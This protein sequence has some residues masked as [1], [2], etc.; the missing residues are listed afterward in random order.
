MAL[1]QRY[2]AGTAWVKVSP[3]FR[4]WHKKMREQVKNASDEYLTKASLDLDTK[5]ARATL[6]EFEANDANVT[7]N[8]KVDK[9]DLARARAQLDALDKNRRV[10][11]VRTEIDN[12]RVRQQIKGLDKK[13]QDVAFRPDIKINEK[14]INKQFDKLR[15]R[16]AKLS[17]DGVAVDSKAYKNALDSAARL[18][19][20]ENE[21][22]RASK[23]RES[24]EKSINDESEQAN[25]RYNKVVRERAGLNRE[26]KRIQDDLAKSTADIV[27]LEN[28]SAK[29][30]ERKAELAE[31]EAQAKKDTR[32]H[33]RALRDLDARRT[34][35]RT[36][37]DRNAAALPG[38]NERAARIR[39]TGN[40]ADW[41]IE[42][43]II[44]AFQKVRKD[45]NGSANIADL[46]EQ[47]KGVSR[48]D[49][50]NAIRRISDRKGA[51]AYPN[52]DRGSLTNRDRAN[53]VRI[54]THENHKLSLEGYQE[55]KKP[56][57]ALSKADEATI[58][59]QKALH[60]Q[61]AADEQEIKRLSDER[62]KIR[63]AIDAAKKRE[64]RAT[65]SAADIGDG[66]TQAADL[67]AAKQRKI[68]NEKA[69]LKTQ[70]KLENSVEDLA[71]AYE[72]LDRVRSKGNQR[73]ISEL[74][75]I[76]KE[77][78]RLTKSR[79][80]ASRVL[81]RTRR[82][83]DASALPAGDRNSKI[84]RPGLESTE[85][86]KSTDHVERVESAIR[87][88]NIGNSPLTTDVSAM[89]NA[90][91]AAAALD[92][93]LA[94]L[95]RSESDLAR[96]ERDV[97]AATAEVNRHRAAGTVT[98]DK[99][100]AA[101]DRETRALE[102]YHSVANTIQ[103]TSQKVNRLRGD[104]NRMAG[105]LN[106][107]LN[108]NGIRRWADTLD[109]KI[110]Q[111]VTKAT[112]RVVLLG[113][114][115]SSVATLAGASAMGFAALGAVNLVPLVG[116]LSQVA[117][118]LGILPGLAAAA[119][120]AIAAIGIGMSGITSA[121]KAGSSMDDAIGAGGGGADNSKAVRS[122]QKAL[123]KAQE[124][125]GKTAQRGAEQVADAEKNV[126]NAQKDSVKA[127]K[128]LTAARKDA[129]QQA[130]DLKAAV[131]GIALSEE[132][133][134][135]S[136]E[137]AA[138]R[139]REVNAD[140]ES[141]S[142][143]RRRA[144]L[145]YK[146]AIE[147]QKNLRKEN[148]KTREE[149]AETQRKGV[150]GS[151][152]VVEAQERVKDAQQGI[153]DAQRDLARTQR[154]AAEANADAIDRV[155]DAQ[156]SLADAMNGGGG[157]GGPTPLDKFNAELD[158]LAP[159]AQ[160]LV[161]GLRSLKDEWTDLRKSTQQS[162]FHGVAEDVMQLAEKYFPLL[163]KGLGDTA[164]GLN[165][166][167]RHFFT[168]LKSEK[169]YLD[170]TSIFNNSG[171]A[172]GNLS[173]ATS[174]FMQALGSVAE[175]GTRFMPWF[176][177]SIAD[178]AKSWRSM[179]DDAQADGSMEAY[180]VR[181]INRSKQLGRIFYDLGSIIKSTFTATEGLGNDSMLHIER[182]LDSYAKK[183]KETAGQNGVREF[184]QSIRN[185]LHDSAQ[186]LGNIAKLVTQHLVPAF[187]MING[188]VGPVVQAI[189]AMSTAIGQIP[190]LGAGI[191]YLVAAMLALKI[192]STAGGVAGKIGDKVSPAAMTGLRNMRTALNNIGSA[193][194]TAQNG[195]RGAT[196]AVAPLSS[197]LTT[198]GQNAKVTS[199]YLRDAGN[200]AKQVGVGAGAF[201]F[202]GP[203]SQ[204]T[205]FS[206][207]V[208]GASANVS[209]LG[210]TIRTNASASILSRL[211][212]GFTSFGNS[213]SNAFGRVQSAGSTAF[214]K[215]RSLGST[216]VDFLG[217][218]VGIAITGVV[219]GL[220][221]WYAHTQK[222][223]SANDQLN[224][225]LV[226]AAA[227][228]KKA[229]Q[230]IIEAR[231]GDDPEVSAAYTS[232]VED[233]MQ[234]NKDLLEKLKT[235]N[236]KTGILSS[237]LSGDDEGLK[238]DNGS[239]GSRDQEQQDRIQRQIDVLNKL[240]I[241]SEDVGSAITGTNDQWRSFSQM[242]MNEGSPAAQQVL[243]D[244]QNQ[245][246]E[247]I[248][249]RDAV[250]DLTPGYLDLRD[251]LET[252]SDKTISAAD[253][254]DALR[255]AFRALNPA[256]TK[257]EALG[258]FGDMIDEMRQKIQS[259]S[260]EGGFG[261]EQL[262]AP[263]G[264]LDTTKQ[265]ANTLFKMM[266][267]GFANLGAAVKNG[268]EFEPLW[269]QFTDQLYQFGDAVGISRD[270]MDGLLKRMG[271][272][273][274][275]IRTTV[276]VEGADTVTQTLA[277]IK[278]LAEQATARGEPR[279]IKMEI[280]DTKV[281]DALTAM[282]IQLNSIAGQPNMVEVNLE[283]HDTYQKLLAIQ[284][285]ITGT[286][287]TWENFRASV[288]QGADGRIRIDNNI[289][290]VQE[291]LNNLKIRTETLPDGSIAII[292]QDEAYYAA[293]VNATKP[294]SVDITFNPKF[295]NQE[296]FDKFL[297][298]DPRAYGP[299]RDTPGNYRGGKIPAFGVGGRMPTTGPGTEK[300]DGFLAVGPDGKPQARVDGGEWVINAAMSHKYN[301]LL[302]LI[303]SDKL[304]GF[305]AGGQMPGAAPAK[306]K[307]GAFGL[308]DVG[309]PFAGMASGV[310]GL[311]AAFGD[312][313][314]TAIPEW[315]QFGNT[316]SSTASKF[317]S[318]ALSSVNSAI[319]EMG[320]DFPLITQT[321]IIPPWSQMASFLSGQK[322]GVLDPMFAG[323][324]SSATQMGNWFTTMQGIVQ[325]TWLSM[326]TQ[327]MAAKTGTIDP[328]FAGIESGL[329]TVESA[330]SNAVP[331]IATLWNGMR[332]ATAAPVRFT[333]NTVLNDG[334]IAAW[335]SVADTIGSK[336]MTGKPAAFARGGV[337][338]GYTP[339]R[340]VH[341][342]FSPTGGELH[343]SGGEAVMRPEWVRA[344]GG[345]S[346]IDKM[347]AEA[348]QGVAKKQPRNR[349]T[350]VDYANG[351]TVALGYGLPPGSSVSYGAAGFPDWVYAL[352]RAHGVQP[353][354]YPGHQ[355]SDRGE[356]GYAPNPQH[357]NRGIDWSGPIPAMDG[358]ARYLLGI[359][360]STPTLEQIIWQNPNTGQQIGW[361]GRQP[362]I[363]GG[364][365]AADYPGHTD[366]VHTRQSGPIAP[367]AVASALG[368]FTGGA[369]GA[370]LD[371]SAYIK[372]ILDP[373]LAETQ[374][375][376]TATKF[377]G[378]TG[379]IPQ[380][381]F[382]T[383]K[384]KLVDKAIE[385]AKKSPLFTAAAGAAADYASGANIPGDVAEKVRKAFELYGWG[386]GAEWEAAKWIIT[387]ESGW[388][389][390][391]VNP[392]S[393][394]W[395]LFQF[396]GA[397][398]DNYYPTNDPD[399][400]KQGQA[401]AKYMKDRYGTPSAAKAFWQAHN[402]YDRG[403]MWPSGTGG[404]NMS[405]KPEAVFTNPQWKMLEKLV[406]SLLNPRMFR[407]LTDQKKVSLG[408]T[409]APLTQ[410]APVPLGD[411]T[412][413]QPASARKREYTPAWEDPGTKAPYITDPETGVPI[414]PKTNKAFTED[415]DSHKPI[416]KDDAT[417]LYVD[418]RTGKYFYGSNAS[419][420]DAKATTGSNAPKRSYTPAW[421]DKD[422][423]PY[424]VDPVTGVPINPDT[425]KPFE[426]DPE[427]HSDIKLDDTTGL[428]VDPK[429]GSYFYGSKA[430]ELDEKDGNKQGTAAIDPE[431]QFSFDDPNNPDGNS[432]DWTENY[433]GPFSDIIK[434]GKLLGTLGQA[435]MQPGAIQRIGN[436]QEMNKQI[437]IAKKRED[438]LN[439]YKTDMAQQISELRAA[440]KTKEA[441]AL[442]AQARGKIAQMKELPGSTPGTQAML[443]TME[444]NPSETWKKQSA[445]QWQSW[446]GEN[447]AGI[448][449][450]AAVM[451]AQGAG[452]VGGGLTVMG[453]L[454]TGDGMRSV[455][456]E[457]DRREARASRANARR[458]RR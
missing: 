47:V 170:F 370:V 323:I 113:R 321:K 36:R 305:A 160:G 115:F 304:E 41:D 346:A 456:R 427:T 383:G 173:I 187:Q 376:I 313:L 399:P 137:E 358:F 159:N 176:S 302:G 76:D 66:S 203:T 449:E 73:E 198:L 433:T 156:E 284:S 303:N 38:V 241:S 236:S 359:A 290:G 396:L 177:R 299:G 78:A 80:A 16:V 247:F 158:K 390:T 57:Q 348:R 378:T 371:A 414:D 375:K 184:F 141:D 199:Q 339:G 87:K 251:A 100:I 380:G 397:T 446:L 62:K 412:Q 350:G 152:Q 217:G 210:N 327:I 330:F 92:S 300:R 420:L 79:D 410:A 452:Q 75:A 56:R 365:F 415:P 328:V 98:S 230:A 189:A 417:G 409:P 227:S 408:A 202:T 150:E 114:V 194:T 260:S 54:G 29:H 243:R 90:R 436:D 257:L 23:Q 451:G 423:K 64:K 404:I 22:L 205:N 179:A 443:A 428:Y 368:D 341:K 102:K 17:N 379:S 97:A 6:R 440:G 136:V 1:D 385:L 226:R 374:K 11:S 279:I 188:I 111:A 51:L 149:Y 183:L 254:T 119:A 25:E 218:P 157:G 343:L 274:D 96:T 138:K 406:E 337:L 24:I 148:Q 196:A 252:L 235:K 400:Y 147:S 294:R 186:I 373:K 285:A 139:M 248:R 130:E 44:R 48:A 401:G 363:G 121:F 126:Q 145:S 99:G 229:Q 387:H 320:T 167:F 455:I 310:M 389:P 86:D 219:V 190:V 224:A 163:K 68:D 318:P 164:A 351:G 5:E 49:F 214:S 297:A 135:L 144:R 61:I 131:D 206:N 35:I 43:Q 200:A 109:H 298:G 239:R 426:E 429:T 306:K 250:Q 132:D 45:G 112:S 418:P 309:N 70:G 342:F 386:S 213:A 353:S 402:W 419:D 262:L 364:Y 88:A 222:L 354:T 197:R 83:L 422:G 52:D 59:R 322:T 278:M 50:D 333:I 445:Q 93:E 172:M 344:Q 435:L 393:G 347:N 178:T 72:D 255:K 233:Q 20:I 421:T 118:A 94:R 237:L 434:K 60:D 392:S 349:N 21:R 211:G 77:L 71:N 362:D 275:N 335:N 208:K 191:K 174:N 122:A 444:K 384:G 282:G 101:V 4:N 65:T 153:V 18:D 291:L 381:A 63:A 123:T 281:R 168:Y 336:K 165:D 32:Q 450:S 312:A 13:F 128:D 67:R 367:G 182:S 105:V 245:R 106:S 175:V 120:T 110:S 81:D 256:S 334:L 154:D 193:S 19:A 395:G 209:G 244:Y 407:A 264:D 253:A 37:R 151:D 366:H 269:A 319:D 457:M 192:A 377:P 382:D 26:A 169:G 296:L 289:P 331:N 263:N 3:D 221:L 204:M 314:G 271:L 30:A 89:R 33:E 124:D 326:A 143:D 270:V 288:T 12:D 293:L 7:V 292:A 85:R 34:A 215:I 295:T 234:A 231:G 84:R 454:N 246:D 201:R 345:P 127:Q 352:G 142:L 69:L 391:A 453:D 166:G 280:P 439:T 134:Q 437:D 329:A 388:N 361:H 277:N 82:D 307:Q 286:N 146:Q 207:A 212:S 431:N 232:A 108:E 14:S 272:T 2:Q 311:G 315:Q 27:K 216:V 411:S 238:S 249:T 220:S 10:I 180:F 332:E 425:G 40:T 394:A 155:A 405:G 413:Q 39:P 53:A 195:I 357:L 424:E 355:E 430:K 15:Q 356:A 432:G 273:P 225:S 438:D 316:L 103:V 181:A 266:E 268:A 91:V 447:W 171:K 28:E 276:S 161:V 42:H 140:P 240:K 398:K 116:T 308:G 9:K 55:P 74:R 129:V 317:I 95:A 228:A 325:P 258:N 261:V 259:A 448:A 416:T 403:G 117:G 287:Q 223:K 458:G 58:A 369:I 338:P 125:V 185:L 442:E 8:A 107:R 267:D 340:D 441:A 162:L 372:G 46:R 324:Q 265:N 242:L 283:D 133:A 301:A 31:R 104:Y 360:P